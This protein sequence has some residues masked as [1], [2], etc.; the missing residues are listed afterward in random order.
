M[1]V[2]RG[3]ILRKSFLMKVIKNEGKFNSLTALKALLDV[4]LH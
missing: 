4:S 2:L 3:Q 1:R